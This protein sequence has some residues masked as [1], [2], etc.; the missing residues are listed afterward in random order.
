MP[1]Q[2]ITKKLAPWHRDIADQIKVEMLNQVTEEFA[3]EVKNELGK[4][5]C[6]NHPDKISYITIMAD[7]NNTIIIKKKFC[8]PAFEEKISVKIRR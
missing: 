3:Q 8:C 5:N 7:R 2:V 6:P 4:L 1:I